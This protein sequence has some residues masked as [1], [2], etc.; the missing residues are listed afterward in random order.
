MLKKIRYDGN[1]SQLKA[2]KEEMGKVEIKYNKYTTIRNIVDINLCISTINLNVNGL[3]TT[4]RSDC[5]NQQ[6]RFH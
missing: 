5:H 1:N 6:K 3:N 2:E 4:I